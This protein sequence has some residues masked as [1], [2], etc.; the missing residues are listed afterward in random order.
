MS[1][2]SAGDTDTVITTIIS[3]TQIKVSKQA[4]L[5]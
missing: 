5:C 2:M 1:Y 4:R 3:Y